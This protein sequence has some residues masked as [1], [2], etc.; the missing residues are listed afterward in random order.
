LTLLQKEIVEAYKQSPNGTALNA[1]PTMFGIRN[2]Q[3]GKMISGKYAEKTVREWLKREGEWVDRRGGRKITVSSLER[4]D[5][6]PS[7]PPTVDREIP[8][9]SKE[10]LLI[11]HDPE[12]RTLVTL[13]ETIQ[14]FTPGRFYKDS[15]VRRA[16]HGNDTHTWRS[17]SNQQEFLPYILELG[18]FQNPTVFWGDQETVNQLL[19][20][21]AS[22]GARRPK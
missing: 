12:T 22:S 17:V 2:P 9:I 5:A 14:T 11:R 15:D 3:T 18:S 1:L 7:N 16:C 8:S 4:A 6:T 10:E 21:N 20:K 19:I 13:R